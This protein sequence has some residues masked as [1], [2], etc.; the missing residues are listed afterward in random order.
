MN[1]FI[2]NFISVSSV[3]SYKLIGDTKY[4]IQINLFFR[5]KSYLLEFLF[6]MEAFACLRGCGYTVIIII[7]LL[8][9]GGVH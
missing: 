8:N 1:F 9:E 7:T 6:I 4:G 5:K 3:F 2:M